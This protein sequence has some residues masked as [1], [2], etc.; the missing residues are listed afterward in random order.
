MTYDA[1]PL[2]PRE[3]LFGN[4][5]R[6]SPSL[7]PD[8]TR[9]GFIA[10]VDGVLNVWVGPSDDPAAARPVTNDRGPWHSH[11]RVLPRRRHLVYLQDTDGNEDWRL[12]ALD[13][14]D[15]RGR[16]ASPREKGVQAQ[17]LGHNRWNPHDGPRRAQR[18][19][20]AA[21]RRL[22]ARPRPT[23]L[24][25]VE[26]NPGFA[27]WL[28]DSD[29]AVRGGMSMTE[30]GGAIVHL[31]GDDGDVRAVQ[32]IA[33]EDVADHR[34]ARLR[35][36]RLG[37]AVM[38]Q[39]RCECVPAGPAR[40]G[41][42]QETGAGRGP[43]VRRQR[44]RARIPR[45][46]SRRRWCSRRT[47]TNGCTSTTSFGAEVEQLR[48][49]GARRARASAA[50][51]ALRPALAG[52]RRAERRC[53][54]LLHVRPR[55]RGRST[56]LFAHKPQLD[57]YVLAPMEPFSF[58]ARD[59]LDVHGYVT[60][61]PASSARDLP[62]VLNVHGGPWARDDW[63][64]DPEAQWLA[65]RGYACVQVNFRGST[66]YGKAFVNAGDKQW[67]RAMHDDLLD[68]VDHVV[69]QGWVDREPGRRSWA[70]RTAATPRWPVPRS[71]PTCSAAPSTWSARPTCSRCS[72]PCPSTGSRRS[73][74]CSHQ[75]SATPRPSATCSG[76]ARRCR[77]STTSASRCSSR[78]AR[79][80][81]GSSRPRPSRSSRRC[82][83]RGSPH[84]YL[85]FEDEGHGLAK[86]ENRERFYARSR[87]VPGRA[88]R[89]PHR[90]P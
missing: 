8:G 43:A 60:F 73:R 61:P 18:R 19:Q 5:E 23:A 29:L 21:A 76:S 67:G 27:G 78:R 12:Y 55:R 1:V 84:E 14:G 86:P 90:G 35:P 56:F 16:A 81:R 82:R 48:R 54:P 10:P 74:S 26:D 7:S 87:G 28:I 50:L 88:P 30:D 66:G 70:A 17:I 49:L 71:R 80:T 44:C 39:R 72:S 13:L 31:R 40:S 85:L 89:R 9:L 51:G 25:K 45:R 46:S 2:V 4:P 58:T 47:A 15:R 83:R 79:T 24:V 32:E 6:V 75:R 38:T 77:A 22:P 36:R 68:A 52:H 42:G 62:A 11:V 20:P 63:G 37:A 33:P 64:Y 3:L 34:R 59:G 53:R 69:E 57:D 41:D 65:N